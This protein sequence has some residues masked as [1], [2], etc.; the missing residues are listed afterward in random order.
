MQP[1]YKQRIKRHIEDSAHRHSNTR[2]PGPSLSTDNI[3]KNL[4]EY[5]RN[6]SEHYSPKQILPCISKGFS[7]RSQNL[8]RLSAKDEYQKRIE[9][10]GDS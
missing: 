9:Q 8:Q 10:C 4:V 7:A 1:E 3:G 6:P 5:H 2:C